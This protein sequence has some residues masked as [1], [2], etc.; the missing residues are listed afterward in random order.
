MSRAGRG[1]G[2]SVVEYVALIIGVAAALT[3]MFGYLRSAF[4]HHLKSGADGLTHGMVK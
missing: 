1:R 2:Q 4:S 3:W